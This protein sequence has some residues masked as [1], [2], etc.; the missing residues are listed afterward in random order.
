M[1]ATLSDG[2]WRQPGA[3]VRGVWR[4]GGPTNGLPQDGNEGRV[5]AFRF[6]AG[7]TVGGDH[8][9]P[10]RAPTGPLIPVGSAG[11][12]GTVRRSPPGGFGVDNLAP[13]GRAGN[14]QAGRQVIPAT[15]AVSFVADRRDTNL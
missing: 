10:A 13:G 3:G 7:R 1:A 15:Q 9:G 14:Q 11:T 8:L 12:A 2:V 4:N 5:I 6:G